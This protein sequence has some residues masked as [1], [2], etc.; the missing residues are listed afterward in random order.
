V[1]RS[2]ASWLVVVPAERAFDADALAELER[3]AR[4]AFE[5]TREAGAVVAELRARWPEAV[6][7]TIGG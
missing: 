1:P 5:R 7:R 4:A 3:L 6:Q 2:G